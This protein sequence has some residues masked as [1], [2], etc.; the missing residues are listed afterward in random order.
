[1]YKGNPRRS[2]IKKLTML[3]MAGLL[4]GVCSL[5]S[6]ASIKDL[7]ISTPEKRSEVITKV[8]GSI[9]NEEIHSYLKFHIYGFAND[10]NV[11]PMFSMNNYVVQK[12][13]PVEQG[14]Y[15]LLHYEVGYFTEFDTNKP[16]THWKNEFTGENVELETFILGPINRMYTPEGVVSPGIAPKPL[17]ISV[18]G[19]RIYVPT[20]SIES[21]PNMFS[22]EE[23]PELSN[24]PKIYW[25]SML[26]FSASVEDVLNPDLKSAP[27]EIHM[28]NLTSW[29]PFLKLGR[30]PG[31]S[32]VRAFGTNISGFE[33]LEPEVRE[34][35]KKITPEIFET[36]TWTDIRFDSL[37][38]YN[39]MMKEK[40]KGE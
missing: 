9:G 34:T 1:M 16:I 15:Q 8:L 28:Q 14:T 24:G 31:R 27:S 35:F 22:P 30:V 39:K 20:Q 2:L 37:D 11:V 25:D 12:W 40:Q 33:A 18:I 10:G 6:S 26:T 21:F 38:Y 17:T 4:S 13:T 36:D 7:D 23:W 5:A 29:Q 32:M 3:G 19:D